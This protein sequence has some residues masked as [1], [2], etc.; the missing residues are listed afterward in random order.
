[1]ILTLLGS[2][3]SSVFAGGATGLFGVGIQ[4]WADYKTKQL[5]L[6]N[7]VELK[8][9]DAAIM[10]QEWAS[11]T[12]IAATEGQTGLGTSADAVFKSTYSDGRSFSQGIT[13]SP[14]QSYLFVF[15]DF[16]RGVIRPLLTVYLCVLTTLIYCQVQSM[17]LDGNLTQEQILPMVMKVSDTILYLTTT[18]V[19]WWFGSRMPGRR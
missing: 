16:L 5:E 7:E 11:R 8:K 6:G 10:A 1:M 3:F 13:P 15:L 9:A 17:L 18:C 14:F 12:Q 2:L 19:L 4:R